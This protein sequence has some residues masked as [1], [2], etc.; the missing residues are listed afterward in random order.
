[1][2]L[3]P[4]GA[5]LMVPRE[6]L[7]FTDCM[8]TTGWLG[9]K[10]AKWAFLKRRTHSQGK[11]FKM[12]WKLRRKKLLSFYL[13]VQLHLCA[14]TDKCCHLTRTFHIVPVQLQPSV[15]TKLKKKRP[16]NC[17]TGRRT[18]ITRNVITAHYGPRG[19][20]MPLSVTPWQQTIHMNFYVSTVFYVAD[21]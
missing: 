6:L 9:R 21:I 16:T 19:N 20:H 14:H 5:A 4:H 15:P 10:G 7:L 1:M 11:R 8:G 2:A 13:H 12:R 18:K 3:E 17:R